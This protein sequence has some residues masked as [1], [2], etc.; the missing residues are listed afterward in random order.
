VI[1]IFKH[2]ADKEPFIID[3]KK[4]LDRIRSGASKS[5]VEKIR[6]LSLKDERNELKKQLPCVLFSGEFKERNNKSLIK[7]S[8]LIVLDFDQIDLSW[9]EYL[10]T[11]PFIYAAW[12]SPSGDGVK[13]LVKISTDNHRGH[14]LALEEEFDNLDKSGKD[15]A[16]IAY[17]SYDPDIYI[18]ENS[19]VFTKYVEETV[20][21]ADIKVPETDEQKIYSNLKRW[22]EKRGE[23][24]ISGNRNNFVLRMACA[25]NRT[26]IS[27]DSCINFLLYDYAHSGSDFTIQELQRTVESAYKRYESQHG[28]MRFEKEDVIDVHGTVMK[29]ELMEAEVEVQDVIYF[30]QVYPTLVYEREHGL[31]KGESTFF[32]RLDEIFRY[33]RGELTVIGGFGNHGKSTFIEQLDLVQSVKKGYKWVVFSPESYPT[34]NYYRNIL[35]AYVGKSVSKTHTNAMTDAEMREGFDF[36]NKH[37][38]YVFPEKVSPTPQY[39]LKRFAEVIIKHKVDGVLIDP[40]NKLANSWGARD[41]KY[42]ESLLPEFER[43]AQNYNVY[44]RMCVHPSKPIKNKDGSY[45]CPTSYDYAGGA[46]WTNMCSNILAYHRPDFFRDPKNPLCEIHSQK[47]KKQGVNGYPGMIE[48]QYDR[49]CFR[50]KENGFNPLGSIDVN[51]IEGDAPF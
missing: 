8:G 30:E 34:H 15:P 27:K 43:F 14:F 1:T 47:I 32:P 37:F 22:A 12:V 6:S 49:S 31:I 45:D 3:H 46:M 24:F 7:H 33:M 25:M 44:F 42:L 5:L 41:D 50:F 48:W 17:E 38:F 39:V 26:G 2:Y 9:K 21:K 19:E 36:V 18:N 20:F 29:E 23:M 51:Y 28:T 13:A 11:L 4:A 16:R 10:K 40:F 35:Q